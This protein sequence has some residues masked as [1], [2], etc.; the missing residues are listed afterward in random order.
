MNLPE[1]PSD[2]CS[3]GCRNKA[4]H[5]KMYCETCSIRIQGALP[6]QFVSAN[7]IKN[8]PPPPLPNLPS[9]TEV[10]N[11]RR[12]SDA[13]MSFKYPKYYKEV[14]SGVTEIDIYLLCN[15]F[16]VQDYSGALHHAIKKI[17]LPG[18]RTGGKTRRD[19]IKEARDTLTR[20]LEIHK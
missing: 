1:N 18:V 19:D 12:S 10:F 17:L 7:T 5:G 20:W 13:K 2:C 16:Q 6:N 11:D 4:S 15:I 9:L 14:P 8:G 3:G